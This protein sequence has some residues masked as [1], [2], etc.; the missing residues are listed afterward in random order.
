M[1]AVCPSCG[2]AVVPGYVKCPKCQTPLP[3]RR[4]TTVAAGGTAVNGGGISLNMVLVGVAVVAVVVAVIALR[5]GDDKPKAA[6][7]TAEPTEPVATDPTPSEPD[8]TPTTTPNQ[9]AAA[10]P[11]A[12]IRDLDRALKKERLW[13]T[14]EIVG[15]RVDVRSAACRESTMIPILEAAVPALRDGGVTTLRCIEQGGAV[16]FESGL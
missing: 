8:V 3:K 16:V 11:T 6:D 2:V 9:P 1:S 12:A 4:A 13:S 14:V 15:T 10:D 7:T 5:G